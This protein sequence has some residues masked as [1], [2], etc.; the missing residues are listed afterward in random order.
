M[1]K[2]CIYCNRNYPDGNITFHKFPSDKERRK[3]W[4]SAMKLPC[5]DIDKNSYLCSEHFEPITYSCQIV[6]NVVHRFLYIEAVPSI[7]KENI[8]TKIGVDSDSSKDVQ[9]SQENENAGTMQACKQNLIEDED[10][11]YYKIL[12]G[13]IHRI[14]KTDLNTFDQAPITRLT[15]DETPSDKI[16]NEI[17]PGLNTA[18]SEIKLIQEAVNVEDS[19]KV[20]V[21]PLFPPPMQI[22]NGEMDSKEAVCDFKTDQN[23]V[24]EAKSIYED[25][26]MDTDDVNLE[27]INNYSHLNGL[28]EIEVSSYE[29]EDFPNG[30][31]KI[32]VSSYEPE[33]FQN[34]LNEVEVSSYEPENFK[35][36]LNEVE[37]ISYDPENIENGLN[38]V[39][40]SSY[41]PE[42]L[43]EKHQ[44]ETSISKDCAMDTEVPENLSKDI[45]EEEPPYEPVPKKTRFRKRKYSTSNADE[46]IEDRSIRNLL[47]KCLENK[48]RTDLDVKLKKY[49][50][51]KLSQLL[52]TALNY[53]ECLEDKLTITTEKNTQYEMQIL[54]L[55]NL[56]Q[57]IGDTET[58]Q[59]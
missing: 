2:V 57:S 52:K 11:Y 41:E 32:E 49:T 30:S 37:V 36:E 25:I 40:V 46:S 16:Q 53:I 44:V 39:E 14:L 38:E 1:V 7:F 12:N 9:I 18:K 22:W 10:C 3:K 6:N 17:N 34:G 20:K 33:N 54:E 45:V 42:N 50:K 31:N 4:L 24:Q 28:H 56:L 5:E 27:I 13:I 58:K 26:R 8:S 15:T 43:E 48:D 23:Q 59:K 35:H 29:P 19:A 47:Y 51:C 21:L 55:E